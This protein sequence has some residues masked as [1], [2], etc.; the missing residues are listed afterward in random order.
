M[1]PALQAD[2]ILLSHWRIF[3]FNHRKATLSVFSCFL[4]ARFPSP[5]VIILAISAAALIESVQLIE[6]GK[7]TE[8]CLINEVWLTASFMKNMKMFQRDFLIIQSTICEQDAGYWVCNVGHLI[9]MAVCNQT[10]WPSPLPDPSISRRTMSSSTALKIHFGIHVISLEPPAFPLLRKSLF[11]SLQCTEDLYFRW[12]ALYL[13]LASL[14][15]TN[16]WIPYLWGFCLQWFP[17]STY[18]GVQTV[19]ISKHSANIL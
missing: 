10:K 5:I 7:W 4:W 2:S 18:Y 6:V 12:P 15:P 19:I 14:S 8:R 13:F 9:R 16:L 17:N 3:P 1:S 11:A